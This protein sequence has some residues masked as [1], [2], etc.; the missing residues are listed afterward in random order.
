MTPIPPNPWMSLNEFLP[1]LNPAVGNAAPVVTIAPSPAAGAAAYSANTAPVS[2]SSLPSG[3]SDLSATPDYAGAVANSVLYS[4]ETAGYPCCYNC[5]YRE[6]CDEH[7]PRAESRF[8]IDEAAFLAEVEP[9]P[10]FLTRPI[11]NEIEELL[12][13]ARAAG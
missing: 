12:S 1:H 3:E 2:M 5:G 13:F 9:V 6:P 11:A 7:C 8:Q 4:E 10:A